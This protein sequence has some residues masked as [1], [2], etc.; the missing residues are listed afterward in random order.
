MPLPHTNLIGAAELAHAATPDWRIFDCRFSLADP[1]AGRNAYA[2]G[3]LPDAFFLDLE[4]DL[5]GPLTGS[6]GRHPLP[7][8]SQLAD[9]LGGLGVTE[10][11]QVIA[12]DDVGGMFAARLWW[13]L[14]W[15]GHDRVAV[16]N[17][18]LQAWMADGRPLSQET[19]EARPA[20]F[21]P[22]VRQEMVVDAKYVLD[23]LH[24]PDMLLIDARSADRY[25]GENENL[26]PVGGHIPGAVNRF[27]K[28]NLGPEGLFK[29]ASEL[30]EEFGRILKGGDA[31][32]AVLQCGS[33]VTACH[34]LLAMEA[35]G[36][37]GARLYAGSWSEWCA[38]PTRPVATGPG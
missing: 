17:G 25:R 24:Q 12:Y 7:A 4:Q 16:L 22:H 11:T 14:R 2:A 27:F 10:A 36:L 13:L 28:D 29:Q 15:L 20:V 26:D 9:T 37:D 30:Q 8:A 32:N 31:H 33:G 35:A 5:S 18:G 38:D 23:H 34:N 6:N 21:T 3:H 19:P 1:Q